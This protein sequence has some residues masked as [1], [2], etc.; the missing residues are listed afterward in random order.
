MKDATKQVQTVVSQ[1]IDSN[2]PLVE[3]ALS[4]SSQ[5]APARRAQSDYLVGLQT[6]GVPDTERIAINEKLQSDGYSLDPLT[7][8]Y[9]AG[10]RPA[11][12]AP[13]STVSYYS[14]SALPAAQQL[15]RFMKTVTGQEFAVQRG[16]GLGVDPSR[17]EV[18][19]FVHYIK[20]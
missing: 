6:L 9:P 17:K 18:T 15:A 16:A 10:E 12:F 3:K 13:R 5:L 8:S 1:T 7:Y 19:L 20:S 4:S 14:A 2:L 11:W